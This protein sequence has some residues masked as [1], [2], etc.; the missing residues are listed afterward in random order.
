MPQ[1]LIQL[2]ESANVD[3]GKWYTACIR[4]HKV[5]SADGLFNVIT[6]V[7]AGHPYNRQILSEFEKY[8]ISYEAAIEYCVEELEHNTRLLERVIEYL[9]GDVIACIKHDKKHPW[10]TIHIFS[11][12]PITRIISVHFIEKIRS[13]ESWD[14]LYDEMHPDS[15]FLANM[16]TMVQNE[17]NTQT[18][19]VGMKQRKCLKV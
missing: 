1:N 17:L 3:F 12:S 15:K 4:N 11:K 10:Y 14:E 13:C 7:V 9:Y 18:T 6:D 2:P 16:K 5:V 8:G 19:K